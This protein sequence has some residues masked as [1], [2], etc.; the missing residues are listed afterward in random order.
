MS[1]SCCLMPDMEHRVISQETT[2]QIRLDEKV[3]FQNVL[4]DHGEVCPGVQGE[5]RHR[6][7]ACR[8]SKSD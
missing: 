7:I 1:Y 4:D 6:M 3:Y 2:P 5:Y 8:S